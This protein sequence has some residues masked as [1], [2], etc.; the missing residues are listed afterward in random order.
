MISEKEAK[1]IL[2]KYS[3]DEESFKMVL[4]H[5]MAVKEAAL[6][7]IKK[8]VKVDKDLI[9]TASLLHDIGRFKCPPDKNGIYHGI[10]GA[11][12]LR[13]EGLP[14]HALVAE[15]HIGV[16]ISKS[17][18]KKQKLKL[19]LKDYIPKS[20]EEKVISYADNLVEGEIIHDIQYPIKRFSKELGKSFGERVRKS[21]KEIIDLQR[22]FIK[23]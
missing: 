6:N 14:K 23:K 22:K 8:I 10:A 17:D 13:K 2:K 18:I 5:S 19:P 21:H 20:I 11:K 7:I 9:K 4:A 12:I 3:P 16:G 15:R 1:S